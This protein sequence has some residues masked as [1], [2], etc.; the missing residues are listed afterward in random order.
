MHK[1]MKDRFY[2]LML[3]YKKYLVVHGGTSDTGGLVNRAYRPCHSET[4]L[5]DLTTNTWEE[6]R[7]KSINRIE[8]SRRNHC[9]AILGDWLIVYG[10]LNTCATYLDDLQVF[11]FNTLHWKKLTL[12]CKRRP[13]PL[14]RSVMQHV[15]HRQREEQPIKDF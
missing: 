1:E 9:G 3:P 4:Y 6:L 7:P 12:R 11:N 10:G 13:P 15:F 2:H 5:Y 8:A 14:C